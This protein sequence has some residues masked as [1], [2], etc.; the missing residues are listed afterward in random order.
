[1]KGSGKF[2]CIYEAIADRDGDLLGDQH[3]EIDVDPLE[4]RWTALTT[5]Q[6]DKLITDLQI[7]GR[8][9]V[10][11]NLATW[12]EGRDLA[13]I[14]T[15]LQTAAGLQRFCRT[16]LYGQQQAILLPTEINGPLR[17]RIVGSLVK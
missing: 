7:S 11:D 3:I 5:Y 6:I 8:P 16:D 4:M 15:A 9:G 13:C 2:G 14:N 12:L 1:M 17:L 10:S